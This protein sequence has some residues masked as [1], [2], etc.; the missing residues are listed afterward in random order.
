MP[1]RD[2]FELMECLNARG[3]HPLIIFVA[4]HSKYA[5]KA[6]DAGA[7]DYLL[8]PFDDERF[9]KAMLRSKAT[10]SGLDRLLVNED[11]RILLIPTRDIELIQVAGKYAKIFARG[12][13]YLARQSLRSVEERL[14]KARFVRIHRSTI[15]NVEQILELHPLLH[16]DCEVVLKRRIRVTVSGRFRSR[17]QPFLVK[18]CGFSEPTKR[19]LL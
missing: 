19:L 10:L 17:L 5:V 16:G 14:D 8:K 7:V 4:A 13:C 9:A 18:W 15:V 2:G 12:H 3:I 1:E 6:Y 11:R